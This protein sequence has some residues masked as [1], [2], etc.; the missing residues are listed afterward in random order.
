MD[1]ELL[2]ET[3]VKL[4]WSLHL[5]SPHLCTKRFQFLGSHEESK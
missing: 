5:E 4:V 1:L 2:E 3:G